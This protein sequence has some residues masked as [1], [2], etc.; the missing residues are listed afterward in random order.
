MHTHTRAILLSSALFAGIGTATF[1]AS[2]VAP[3]ASV[4]AAQVAPAKSSV[5]SSTVVYRSG[6][7]K[8]KASIAK[9][10]QVSVAAKKGKKR[11]RSRT[12]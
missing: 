6:K 5:K 9:A 10:P 7:A 1:V 2:Q 11:Y 3:A 4:T 8:A 12:S